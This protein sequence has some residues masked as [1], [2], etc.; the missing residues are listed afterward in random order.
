MVIVNLQPMSEAPKDGTEILAHSKDGG[1]FHPVYWK[2]YKLEKDRQHWG[3]RWHDEY[4][5]YD[6]CFDGWIPY[7]TWKKC[8]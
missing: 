7:P 4:H 5:Q 3:M 1:N 6:G 2:T 8:E